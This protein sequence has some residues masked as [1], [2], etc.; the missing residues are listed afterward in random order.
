METI[1]LLLSGFSH[2]M[3][4]INLIWLVAGSALGTVLGM[5]PGLGPTTGIALLMPLTFTMAPDTALVT[6]CAI[7]YGA[8][9]GGSRSSILLNV[10]GDGAAVASCFDGYPMSTSGQ[11]EAALAISAIASFIGGLIA[12]I[13]FVAVA[14]PVARF[15]LK[16]GPPE[17][18]M[19]MCFALAATAAISKEAM[20]KGLLSMCLGLMI[21]TVGIDP[22]SGAIRFT[23]GVTALQTGIDFVVV[24]IGVYGLGEVFHNMDH[25]RSD[26]AVKVQS[27]FGRIWV[28]MAQFKRCW[29]PMIRQTPVGFFVGVLPGAGATIAALMA[30]N[31]EKQLSKNPENFGKGEIVGL[32]A[33]EAANN[34]CS[35]GALIP[36]MTLGVPGSGTTAVMLGALMILGLQPGPLLF[37]QHADIAWT[38]IASMFLGNVA[39]AFINIPL[40]SLL[41]RVLAVPT[42]ILYPLIV[43]MAL[44]GVYTINFSVVDFVLLV[45]FGLVGY[46][47]KKYKVPTSPLILAVVVGVSMEQSYRQS[48]MLSDGNFAILFRSPICWVLFFL[49]IF[50]IVWPFFSDWKKKRKSAAQA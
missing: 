50:S 40:A 34:A 23:F 33:P 35:V 49:T 15:A 37:Q 25:I 12:T 20:L 4:P 5:L 8:M 39:C 36:M 13:A 32:A 38:V 10:P 3:T 11:A 45:I 48:M 9:F 27:K 16:F 14:V 29:W 17:Y 26:V 28:T 43:A 6:M 1:Q 30:Y 41:V 21:A 47:M 22:Q 18:F 24:I 19:L 2:A 42:K 7:Y 46:F 31:N 44:I